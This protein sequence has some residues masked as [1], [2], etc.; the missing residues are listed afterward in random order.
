MKV[1]LILVV[2]LFF[3]SHRGFQFHEG[4]INTCSLNI[5]QLRLTQF[6][7]H[8]GSINTSRC[9]V[10]YVTQ[11]RFQFHEGSINTM[12]V[13]LT[14]N[15]PLDFNSMKVRLI[16][17]NQWPTNHK[18]EFQFHEGSINTAVLKSE[19][20]EEPLFQFHEGSINTQN[21]INLKQ[22]LLISIPWRFD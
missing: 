15:E 16:R 20:Y 4:S 2:K 14:Q 12:Q 21:S 18:H 22:N 19:G 17:P 6:Q 5:A 13:L 7:F 10:L 3:L 1:R 11:L 8:E 9:R